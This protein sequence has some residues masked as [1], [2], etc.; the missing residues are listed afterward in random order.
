MCVCVRESDRVREM[1]EW[2]MG[3]MA[4]AMALQRNS[5]V[6]YVD[7]AGKGVPR[8]YEISPT[9]DPA[10]GLCLGPYGGSREGCCFS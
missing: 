4:V 9:W 5:S 1:E 10:V 8:S 2:F 3:G 6:A 7:F